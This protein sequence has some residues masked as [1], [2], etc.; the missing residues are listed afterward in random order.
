MGLTIRVWRMLLAAARRVDADVLRDGLVEEG[1]SDRVCVQR[2]ATM[3][4]IRRVRAREK[5]E[6]KGEEKDEDGEDEEEENEIEFA[7]A[8]AQAQE[9]DGQ[10]SEADVWVGPFEGALLRVL[11]A[12]AIDVLPYHGG[13]FIG[14]HGMRIIHEAPKLA[15]ALSPRSFLDR[16]RVARMLGDSAFEANLLAFS[17]LLCEIHAISAPARPICAHRQ[18]ELYALTRRMGRLYPIWF[19]NETIP[20]KLHLLTCEFAHF[21][22]TNGSIGMYSEESGEALHVEMNRHLSAVRGMRGSQR[23]ATVMQQQHLASNPTIHHHQPAPR[24]CSRCGTPLRAREHSPACPA[25]QSR[26]AKSM[27]RRRAKSDRITAS[28]TS[29]LVQPAR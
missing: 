17:S 13:T 24:I 26:L 14:R 9:S 2:R 12:L 7:I 1:T 6:A 18:L 5:K 4:R 27:A 8:R 20:P 15:A 29:A 19:P 10:E 22:W 28:T 11:A 23:L 25:A 16:H 21:A 3:D